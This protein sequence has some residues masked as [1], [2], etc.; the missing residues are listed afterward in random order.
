MRYID[1]GL[2]F[3]MHPNTKDVV[4]LTD[5]QAIKAA[6]KHL[7][8]TNY[9][10]IPFSP[11]RGGNISALMFENYTGIQNAQIQVDIKNLIDRYEPRVKFLKCISDF[12]EDVPALAVR[13]YFRILSLN[14]DVDISVILKRTR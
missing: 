14:K 8:L 5:E 12:Y 9:Y 11:Y 2:S 13:I 4:Q 6:V 1:V 7:V 10:E 3:L